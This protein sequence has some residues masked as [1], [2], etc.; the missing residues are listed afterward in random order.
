MQLRLV[1]PSCSLTE[2]MTLWSERSRLQLLSVDAK[3]RVAMITDSFALVNIGRSHEC[4]L[5]PD[6][7]VAEY[8]PMKKRGTL[9][10]RIRV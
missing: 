3:R 8:T 9:T 1:I 7:G 6:A 10:R 5:G 4:K 2:F